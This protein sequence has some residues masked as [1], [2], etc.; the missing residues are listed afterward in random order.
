MFLRRFVPG[1]SIR[2]SERSGERRG[3]ATAAAPIEKSNSRARPRDNRRWLARRRFIGYRPTRFHS[4]TV[5]VG[6]VDR[7]AS[8]YWLFPVFFYRFFFNLTKLCP[9]RSF[10]GHRMNRLL[11]IQNGHRMR[12]AL[13]KRRFPRK[14]NDYDISSSTLYWLSSE[15]IPR[16]PLL[17]TTKK[18]DHFPWFSIASCDL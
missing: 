4:S 8:L 7:T 13:E 17:T 11:S 6:I 12:R 16:S 3:G 18:N 5:A 15:S 9:I 1:I 14:K 2:G 10:G